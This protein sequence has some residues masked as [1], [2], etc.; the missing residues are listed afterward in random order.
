MHFA[1]GLTSNVISFTGD[2]V[3][4]FMMVSAFSMCCGYF[5]RFRV[6]GTSTPLSMNPGFMDSGVKPINL[7][8]FYRKRY[9]RVLPFFGLLKMIDVALC[10]ASEHLHM[11][12]TLIGELWEAFA[13]FTLAFGLIPGNDISVIGAHDICTRYEIDIN[14]I[15]SHIAIQLGIMPGFETTFPFN[16]PDEC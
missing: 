13:N 15:A 11:T 8:D 10:A 5:E 9:K 14:E 3:L 16:T 12:D 1:F 7:N 6:Y 2:F 4:M